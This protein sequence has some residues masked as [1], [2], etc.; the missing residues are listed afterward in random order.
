MKSLLAEQAMLAD[1]WNDNVT[2]EIDDDGCIAAVRARQK[3]GGTERA[4]GPVIPGMANV[5]SHAFQ[6]AMAG[7]S[8]RMGSPEDSFWTWREVM[9][10]FLQRL[11]PDQVCAIAAQLYGEMLSNGYTS[12]GEFHYL[13][14]A[15][16]GRPY[17]RSTEMARA[18]LSLLSSFTWIIIATLSRHRRNRTGRLAL[19]S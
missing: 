18:L 9:Y 14:H 13:H 4:G 17:A 7:L 6:R 15:P 10:S 5:H 16:D 1:G 12:V 3:P 8:E 11:D 19:P 2:I